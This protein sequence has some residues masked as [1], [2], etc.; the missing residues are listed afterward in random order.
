MLRWG[1]PRQNELKLLS[2]AQP[3]FKPEPSAQPIDDDG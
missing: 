2:R 1:N 3:A